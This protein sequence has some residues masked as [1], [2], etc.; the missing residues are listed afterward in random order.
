MEVRLAWYPT[1]NLD[2]AKKFYGESLGLQQVFEMDGWA[3]FS[4]AS[5]ATSIG[6]SA[7]PLPGQNTGATI[8]LKVADLDKA[9]AELS[10]KGIEFEGRTEEIPGVV[11]LATFRDPFGNPLQLVQELAEQ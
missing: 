3:E 7:N 10:R 9:R 1:T 8:V 6:L 11:R 2:E 4:H 5:G